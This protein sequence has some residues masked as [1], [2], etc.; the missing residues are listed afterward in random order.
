MPALRPLKNG[1]RFEVALS[2][3]KICNLQTTE[4]II[5]ALRYVMLLVGV[6]AA[7]LPNEHETSI[8]VNYISTNYGGHTAEEIKLAFEKAINGDLDIDDV[9]CYENFSVLYFAKV[10]NAYRS[11]ASD[12][13]QRACVPS[14]PVQIILTDDQLENLHRGDIENFY[15]RIL[16]GRVPYN[17]PDYFKPILV[18]DGLMK[19]E[20]DLS[21]FFVQRLGRGS[22]NIYVK[23]DAL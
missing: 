10:M 6:R 3:S 1:E 20:D 11:W 21:I 7:N 15:Q 22:K 4:P 17:L 14:N 9:T 2:G 13:Y 19:Q 8:L 12:Q 23:D 5:Q 16:D 18:K